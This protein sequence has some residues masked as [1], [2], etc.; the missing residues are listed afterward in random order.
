MKDIAKIIE[1]AFEHR[2]EFKSHGPTS[3]VQTAVNSAIAALDS[4]NERVAEPA[5]SDWLVND[6]LKK[7]VLLSFTFRENNVLPS[8]D[9]K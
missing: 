6:W 5:G 7:A 4:G 3:E 1:D 8:G 9:T 2:S